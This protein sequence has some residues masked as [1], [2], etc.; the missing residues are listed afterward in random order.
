MAACGPGARRRGSGGGWGPGAR[1]GGGRGGERDEA[2]RDRAR[3]RGRGTAQG[4]S[5]G[6]RGRGAAQGAWRGGGRGGG[7]RLEVPARSARSPL[8]VNHLPPRGWGGFPGSL[9]AVGSS[10]SPLV[11]AA[12][13]GLLH[14]GA[15]LPTQRAGSWP[16]AGSAATPKAL[17]PS[18]GHR[19]RGPV[20][21]V[22]K[23]ARAAACG[24]GWG[25][26]QWDGGREQRPG[27]GHG[28]AGGIGWCTPRGCGGLSRLRW[29][30]A[31]TA[32]HQAVPRGWVTVVPPNGKF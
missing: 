15:T 10:S 9:P 14:C 26:A 5:R 16:G 31:L 13:G 23:G 27:H 28:V 2:C 8:P 20:G 4:E 22:N 25:A 11:P 29:T 1:G 12:G 24:A 6:G 30:S 21:A 3:R 32:S 17:G 19:L 18:R 7:R